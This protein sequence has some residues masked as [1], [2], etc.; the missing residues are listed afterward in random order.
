MNRTSKDI[1]LKCVSEDQVNY[2][3]PDLEWRFKSSLFKNLIPSRPPDQVRDIA[4]SSVG[5]SLKLNRRNYGNG[6]TQKPWISTRYYS[7][8]KFQLC[9]IMST[10]PNTHAKFKNWIL[11]TPFPRNKFGFGIVWNDFWSSTI[12]PIQIQI[13]FTVLWNSKNPGIH[14]SNNGKLLRR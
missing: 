6:Y 1:S 12:W 2:Y 3:F 13:L 9:R 5:V 7:S 8:T 4:F 14:P 10:Y 11:K